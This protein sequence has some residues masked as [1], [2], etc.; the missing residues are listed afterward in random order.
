MVNGLA[1]RKIKGPDGSRRRRY[2]D[3]DA[4]SRWYATHRNT[5]FARR[6]WAA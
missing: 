5:R 2:S 3:N 4:R 6:L 1:K